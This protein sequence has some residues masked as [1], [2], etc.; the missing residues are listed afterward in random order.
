MP[1]LNAMKKSEKLL[2]KLGRLYRQHNITKLT[3]KPVMPAIPYIDI[4][5]LSFCT[6]QYP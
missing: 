3:K 5:E 6:P 1:K 2:I 4:S